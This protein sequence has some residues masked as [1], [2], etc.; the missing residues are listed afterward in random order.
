MI[1]DEAHQPADPAPASGTLQRETI[2]SAL[3][4]DYNALCIDTNIFHETAY[5]FNKG[6]LAQVHQFAESPVQVV[7]SEIVDREIRRHLIERIRDA[8][9]SLE[10]ALKKVQQELQVSEVSANRARKAIFT[11]AP[12]EEIAQRRL[13]EFYERCDAI[14]LPADCVSSRDV[15]DRYFKHEPPFEAIGDKKLEF[16]DA[17]ALMSVEKWAQEKGSRVLVVSRDQGWKTFCEESE[18]LVHRAEL[19]SALKLL[20]RHDAAPRLLGELNARLLAGADEYGV[21]EAITEGIRHGVEAME[22]DVEADSHY[23]WGVSDVYAEYKSH[24]FHRLTDKHMDI[25]LVRVTE[26]DLTVRFSATIIC[27]V[28]ASFGL[29]MTDPIDKDQVSLGSQRQKVENHYDSDVL[30]TF[31]G[32]FAQ[33]LTGVSVKDVEV[34]HDILAVDF[35]EIE[36]EWGREDSAEED[37]AVDGGE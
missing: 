24:E 18:H 19:G 22:V 6:L 21:Q 1:S 3:E 35:G 26:H 7:I 25:D 20:Q 16:P 37:I 15:L 10:K 30:V 36:I 27:D 4:L 8:R 2:E 29:S 32:D 11:G 28:H 9:D 14:V 5:T 31:D 13:D 33:G 23:Y 34:V 12:D 17:Y